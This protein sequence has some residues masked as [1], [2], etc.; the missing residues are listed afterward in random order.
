[1]M[2]PQ[3]FS[4]DAGTDVTVTMDIDPDV[5]GQTLVGSTIYFRAYV[6]EHGN[7]VP[8]TDPVIDKHGESE[9]IVVTDA[10]A[11]KVDIDFSV[12]ETA[13][14]LRNYVFEITLIDASDKITRVAWG[15]MTV[16][17]TEYRATT[18]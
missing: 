7:I 14:L 8:G 17:G 13:N 12:D 5:E 10:D 11:Q 9:G 16:N 15:M 2:D 3:N 1:M 6:Q 4:I 18:S